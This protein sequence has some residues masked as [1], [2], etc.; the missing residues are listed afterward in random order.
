VKPARRPPGNPL[1]TWNVDVFAED[2]RLVQRCLGQEADA[3]RAL[4]ERFQGE[5]FGLCVRLLGDRHEAEDVAQEVFLRVFRSLHRWD[6]SRPLR[7][8]IMGITVNRCRTFLGRRA[9]RPE[10]ADYLHDLPAHRPTD[11]AAE[12]LREIRLALD[13]LRPDYREVFVLFHEQGQSYDAIAAALG[14][15]VGTVKTWLHR[16]RLEVLEQLRRRGM[17][18]E[19]GHE[20]S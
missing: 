13:G 18:S 17:V 4:V 12:L 5:V 7:P 3:I 8:W 1:K 14:R 20:L 19:V 11:D 9:R 6:P 16:A 2:A 15:P 10:P